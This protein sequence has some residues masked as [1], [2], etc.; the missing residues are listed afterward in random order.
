[1]TCIGPVKD[2]ARRVSTPM[3][4]AKRLNAM[5]DIAECSKDR[6]KNVLRILRNAG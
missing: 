1:M 6:E 3:Q 4:W 2:G 5:D